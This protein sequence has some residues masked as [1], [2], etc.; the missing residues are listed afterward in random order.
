MANTG[1]KIYRTLRL[2]K[3]GVR[4]EHVKPND[5]R[6]PNHIP[7]FTDIVSCFTDAPT[8]TPA[9]VP[10]PTPVPVVAPT[11]T[12]APITPTPTPT[13]V[14]GVIVLPPAV[15]VKPPVSPAPVGGTG[16]FLSSPDKNYIRLCQNNYIMSSP[17]SIAGT[18]SVGLDKMV[19]KDGQPFDGG[20]FWYAAT[21]ES[22]RPTTQTDNGWY[23]IQIMQDG[24]IGN[25]TLGKLACR[26]G[27]MDDDWGTDD[28]GGG[29]DD[30]DGRFLGLL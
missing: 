16:I 4:T 25:I 3:D 17:A 9:P 14:P 30:G 10:T 1:S 12:P 28:E 2:Y 29:D 27:M 24:T 11:P 15:V 26:G 18:L 22:N 7:P 21:T 19:S 6:D 20:G 23:A 5:S 13:P 8:P